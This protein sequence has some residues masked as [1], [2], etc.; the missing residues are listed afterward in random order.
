MY[1]NKIVLERHRHRWEFNNDYLEIFKKNGYVISAHS[2]DEKHTA[3]MA[4]IKNHPFFF[5][6]QFHPEFSS[7]PNNNDPC[8]IGL[9]K[10]AIKFHK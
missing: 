4:E 8:F 5:G 10:A 7:K 6:G 2:N 9:I 1:K 3:E